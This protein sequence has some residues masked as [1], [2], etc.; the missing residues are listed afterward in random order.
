MSAIK[1]PCSAYTESSRCH[2][3]DC[4]FW[5][6]NSSN[7]LALRPETS[8]VTLLVSDG[9]GT[10]RTENLSGEAVEGAGSAA[11]IPTWKSTSAAA[12]TFLATKGRACLRDTSCH[13]QRLTASPSTQDSASRL[14]RGAPPGRVAGRGGQVARYLSNLQLS[15]TADLS[16]HRPGQARRY[17][18]RP[19]CDRC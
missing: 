8:T 11:C 17:F 4:L 13:S 14:R 1:S 2:C 5:A 9:S 15:R 7:A 6:P 19:R 16:C 18:P 3:G 12:N 10:H